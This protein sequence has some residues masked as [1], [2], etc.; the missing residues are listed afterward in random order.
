MSTD[1][2][3]DLIER[4]NSYYADKNYAA[5]AEMLSDDCSWSL[6]VRPDLLPTA[7]P[8][9]KDQY[10]DLLRTMSS[11]LEGGMTMQVVGTVAQD[12]R[13]A[14]E[15]RS[16]ALAKNGKIYRNKYHI[17]YVISDG[18]I[19]DVREYTDSAQGAGIFHP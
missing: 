7:D 4:F 6:E 8:M 15:V 5:M 10:L 16:H 3:I 9:T 19:S 17:L 18:K 12:D 1:D 11:A 2:N 14:A 13:V